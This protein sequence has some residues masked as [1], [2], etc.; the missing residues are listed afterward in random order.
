MLLMM[1][2]DCGAWYGRFVE[3]FGGGASYHEL[4][5][6]ALAATGSRLPSVVHDSGE[7]D[8]QRREHYPADWEG[9]SLGAK[10]AATQ[11]AIMAELLKLAK[12][13][14]AEVEGGRPITRF[15]LTGGLSQSPFFQQ[16]FHVGVQQ[17]A[18]GAQTLVGA[19]TDEL[20]YQTA[21]YGALINAMLP[22]RGGDLAA[23][24]RELCPLTPC[25]RPQA[26]AATAWQEQLRS[27]L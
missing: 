4:N 22:A 24:C 8:P 7:K 15:V 16:A 6:L 9:A 23:I 13:M 12:A 21:A 2:A 19:Q 11:L 17:L 3:R 25:D 18:P 26:G 14:L 20:S 1:L 5:N 27:A 10:T